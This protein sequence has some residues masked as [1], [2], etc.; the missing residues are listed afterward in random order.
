MAQKM[1]DHLN[2]EIEAHSIFN[3]NEAS[4]SLV[5]P[6]LPHRMNP[7]ILKSIINIL[8]WINHIFLKIGKG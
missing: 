3:P 2:S 1:T 4:T 7:V 8:N 5:G 6:Q